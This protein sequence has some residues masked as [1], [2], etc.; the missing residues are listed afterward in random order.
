MK[1]TVFAVTSMLVM[2]ALGQL[3][4]PTITIDSMD[5]DAVP[6]GRCSLIEA[7]ENADAAAAGNC[8]GCVIG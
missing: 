4:P 7:I 1:R 3:R 6:D 8:G 2:G 5:P